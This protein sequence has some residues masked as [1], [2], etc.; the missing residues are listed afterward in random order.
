MF[1]AFPEAVFVESEAVLFGVCAY[2]D[3][4]LCA[5]GEVEECGGEALWG[6]EADVDAV[7]VVGAGADVSGVLCACV[8]SGEVCFEESV[9]IIQ[10]VLEGG[11]VGAALHDEVYVASGGGAAA[12][13]A[14]DFE[15]CSEMAAE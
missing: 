12:V 14:G 9:E 3:V 13:G 1:G 8:A 5:A 2:V 15:V 11:C 7:E 4:E 6:H 10:Y